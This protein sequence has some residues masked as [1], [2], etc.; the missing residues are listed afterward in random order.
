[1]ERDF[2][3]GIPV[4]RVK[5]RLTAASLI[6]GENNFHTEMFKDFDCRFRDIIEKGIAEASAHE[7]NFLS[8]RTG[9]G[10]CHAGKNIAAFVKDFNARMQR[11]LIFSVRQPKSVAETRWRQ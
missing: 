11:K 9:G 7:Q 3:R 1:V 4:A 8:S 5:G 10:L 2:A 6:L